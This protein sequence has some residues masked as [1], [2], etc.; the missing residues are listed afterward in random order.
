MILAESKLMKKHNVDGKHYIKLWL[1]Y[2]VNYEQQELIKI[3]SSLK[4][5]FFSYFAADLRVERIGRGDI[6]YRRQLL[7]PFCRVSAWR[8]GLDRV[9]YDQRDGTQF[10]TDVLLH[11]GKM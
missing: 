3:K 8:H 10:V 6:E 1:V 11:R 4:K 9:G 7:Q 2:V 5:Y